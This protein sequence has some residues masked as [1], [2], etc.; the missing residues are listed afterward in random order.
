MKGAIVK[1]LRH[2]DHAPAQHRNGPIYQ[3]ADALRGALGLGPAEV[4]GKFSFGVDLA[5]E[6]QGDAMADAQDS[7]SGLDAILDGKWDEHTG[8]LL[9]SEDEWS[10]ITIARAD[11]Y[12]ALRV[13]DPRAQKAA[14]EKT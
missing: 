3:A 13:E 12:K 1:A 5:V 9:L 11:L 8:S 4:G 10:S 14:G 6:K 7:L 2:L